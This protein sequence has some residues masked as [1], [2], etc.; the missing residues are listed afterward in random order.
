M[1]TV[2]NVV[3]HTSSSGI[4]EICATTAVRNVRTRRHILLRQKTSCVSSSIMPTRPQMARTSRLSYS[5]GMQAISIYC[6]QHFMSGTAF[7]RFELPCESYHEVTRR[8]CSSSTE[9]IS[10]CCFEYLTPGSS[11]GSFESLCESYCQ[12][13]RRN[14]SSST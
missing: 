14:C 1:S 8:H 4:H 6:C 10:L 5:S 13:T 9:A 3:R 12:V 2:N 7:R 11:F